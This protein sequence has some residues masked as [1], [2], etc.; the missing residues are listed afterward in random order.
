MLG[1]SYTGSVVPQCQPGN[2]MLPHSFRVVNYTSA[3]EDL[4][5]IFCS[6]GL[7]PTGYSEH[8]MRRGGAT[9]AA[10]QGASVGE[11]QFAGNWS[12]T[13]TVEKY[14]EA[15]H[16]RARDFNQYLL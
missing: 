1:D 2:R 14:I 16:R 9:E 13:R 3:S 7:D 4:R 5:V 6:A 11:I 8:S 15:S 10:R 12:C